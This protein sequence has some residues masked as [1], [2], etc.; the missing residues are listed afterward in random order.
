MYFK[1]VVHNKDT[2]NV[3]DFSRIRS[4]EVYLPAGTDW[5]DFW[6]N[7]KRNGGGT[8]EKE[9]P[10]DIIPLYVKSG[11]IIPFGPKVQYAE[12]KDWAS[13]E[14]R[15][16]AGQDGEF[17]L[18]EDENDNYNYERDAYSLINLKW[19]DKNRTLII[20]KR[21]GKFDGMLANR[22]FDVVLIEGKEQPVPK[23][24]EYSGERVELEL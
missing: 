16:Y 21:K 23:K 14:I 12:E 5:Y 1:P 2:V 8:V 3:E 20:D 7:E 6:T 24:V 9:T 18:Y 11:S 19:E 4:E 22:S 13:L 15:V 17:T 10:I